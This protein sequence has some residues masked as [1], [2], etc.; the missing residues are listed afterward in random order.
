[1]PV[2]PPRRQKKPSLLALSLVAMV[3]LLTVLV[4]A[5]EFY[6]TLFLVR[7]EQFSWSPCSY[8]G[9][10]FGTCLA[11]NC[12]LSGCV[13]PGEAIVC[14]D[15]PCVKKHL[16]RRGKEHLTGVYRLTIPFRDERGT[17]A[18]TVKKLRIIESFEVEE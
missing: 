10:G 7:Y 8:D 4:A 6:G 2:K 16:E 9:S 13:S 1:M 11:I 14:P 12:G 15:I 17:P 5:E 18:V 3:L